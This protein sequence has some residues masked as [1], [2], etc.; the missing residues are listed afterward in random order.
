[1]KILSPEGKLFTRQVYNWLH[2][3]RPSVCRLHRLPCSFV[4]H[5][6][7]GSY[8]VQSE[9][10]DYD[11]S[12]MKGNYVHDF[13][14][15]PNQTAELEERVMELHKTHRFVITNWFVKFLWKFTKCFWQLLAL[16]R[17]NTGR[18]IKKEP[19]LVDFLQKLSY[20]Q[21]TGVEFQ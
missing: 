8:V 14:F 15:A 5:T 3:V 16:K 2:C 17:S 9:L 12:E 11:R 7:L 19:I 18:Q 13:A 4:T 6:L 1:M 21:S 10:G 20:I